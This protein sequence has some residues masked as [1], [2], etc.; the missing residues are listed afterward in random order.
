MGIGIVAFI[1]ATVFLMNIQNGNR[2]DGRKTT[3][4]N[5][6]VAGNPWHFSFEHLGRGIA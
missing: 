3:G 2:N 5:S 6:G 4:E 1:A